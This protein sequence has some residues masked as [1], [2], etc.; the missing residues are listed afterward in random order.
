MLISV[1]VVQAFAFF[2][3]GMDF[4]TLVIEFVHDL[5]GGNSYFF[6]VHPDPW[7]NGI[8]FDEVILFKWVGSNTN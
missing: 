5:G 2:V 3:N 1:D 6:N 4:H 7:G 8:Q